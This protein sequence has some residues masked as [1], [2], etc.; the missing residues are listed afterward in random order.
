MKFKGAEIIF[1]GITHERDEHGGWNTTYLYEGI[2]PAVLAFA[3]ATPKG[4]RVNVTQNGEIS[5]AAVTYGNLDKDGVEEVTEKWEIDTEN[6]SRDIFRTKEVIALSDE[7]KSELRRWRLDPASDLDLA[8][9]VGGTMIKIKSL[10]LA[11]TSEVEVATLIL[12]RSRRMSSA[13]IPKIVLG[14]QKDFFSTPRLITN[15]NIP[16]EIAALLPGRNPPNDP[17]EPAA[18]HAWGW[19]PRLANRSFIGRGQAEEQ[20]DWTFGSISKFLY[21]YVP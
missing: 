14:I 9:D 5:Q 17:Y 15:E 21:N 11:G 7:A 18:D 13:L 3:K 6:I 19:M 10:I 16:N 12:K 8:H 4:P 2:T 20:S 1:R